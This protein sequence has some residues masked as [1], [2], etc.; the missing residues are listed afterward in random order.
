MRGGDFAHVLAGAAAILVE[1]H[2]LAAI[3][4]GKA[5]VACAAQEGQPV[6]VVA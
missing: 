2:Q 5:E 1:R 3:L 4:D 6:N